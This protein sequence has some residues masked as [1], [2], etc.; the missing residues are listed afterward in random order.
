M[1]AA[2]RNFSKNFLR[3]VGVPKNPHIFSDNCARGLRMFSDGG[4]LLRNAVPSGTPARDTLG[5][6]AADEH[7]ED[8]RRPPARRPERLA[9]R[10]GCEASG[11][12]DLELD[13]GWHRAALDTIQRLTEERFAQGLAS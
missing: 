10:C 11:G 6:P 3:F 8:C 13:E 2:R 5:H 7:P 1:Q 4:S 9:C 12:R